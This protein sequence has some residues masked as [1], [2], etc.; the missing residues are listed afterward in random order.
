MLA[1]DRLMIIMKKRGNNEGKN[2]K[3]RQQCNA[4]DAKERSDPGDPS[5][6]ENQ[7]F[8]TWLRSSTGVEMMRLFVIANSMLVFVTM[9][10]PNI[11]EF[12]YIIK[13]YLA[14]EE[15]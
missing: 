1:D 7:G 5:D 15:D 13:N 8:G 14:G 9:A 6:D 10:W 2:S 12:F 3:D 11:K 4:S